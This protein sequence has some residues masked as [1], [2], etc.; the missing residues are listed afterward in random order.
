M[1]SLTIAVT[2]PFDLPEMIHI[3]PF[4]TLAL[5]SSPVERICTC[6][7]SSETTW[8]LASSLGT[9]NHLIDETVGHLI[10]QVSDMGAPKK[11]ASTACVASLSF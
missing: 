9:T 7:E 11:A 8:P 4:M 6:K 3:G 2:L 1:S 5:A 10:N